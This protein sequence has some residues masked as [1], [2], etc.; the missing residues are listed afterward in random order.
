MTDLASRTIDRHEPILPDYI[1]GELS[2]AQERLYTRIKN[3]FVLRYCNVGQVKR[4]VKV[5]PA[6]TA[7][8]PPK[9]ITREL[10]DRAQSALN[11]CELL[12]EHRDYLADRGLGDD[13]IRKFS[14][15]SAS[16]LC[17][18]L[19]PTDIHH[20]SLRLSDKFAAKVSDQRIEG[21]VV[22]YNYGTDLYGFCTRILNHDLFKYSITIPQRCCFGV[23]LTRLDSLYVVEGVFDAMILILRGL[24]A[25]ALGDS[26]PNYWKMF[27]AHKFAHINLAFDNDY[28]GLIGAC[29]AHLILEEMLG[30]H[31][32][33][34]SLLVPDGK[35]PA[36]S[37]TY[38]KH[39]IKELAVRL[40][41]MGAQI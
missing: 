30:R 27:V 14:L 16:K 28:T 31:P 33:N 41:I 29:K 10:L 20:L 12:Q 38:R 2:Q 26:Q 15:C 3:Q 36:V 40:T 9:V 32:S 13:A 21:I 34:I 6:S 39:T 11:G 5:K 35:D 7:T 4:W 19:S 25:M 24:N 1:Q 22:P 37:H 23:D 18:R 17:A 8:T